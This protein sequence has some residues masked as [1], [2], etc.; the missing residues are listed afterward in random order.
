MDSL[1][2]RNRSRSCF[3]VS[4]IMVF[5]LLLLGTWGRSPALGDGLLSNLK[6]A[7]KDP[8][9]PIFDLEDLSALASE[10]TGQSSLLLNPLPTNAFRENLRRDLQYITTWPANGWS[11]QVIE[12]MNMIYIAQLTHRVPIIPRFRPVHINNENA[13]HL[14]FG[15]VFDVPLLSQTLGMPILEWREVKDAASETLEELG[16]WDIQDKTWERERLYL[17]AP[18]NL[19]LD[20]SYTLAPAWVRSATDGGEDPSTLLWSVAALLS[21]PHWKSLP[22]KPSPVHQAALP[23]DEHLACSNN[24]Y[25]GI[26]NLE[27]E[28][29]HA[30]AWHA[31]GRHIQ[32][33]SE[34]RDVGTRFIRETLGVEDGEVI[35]PYIAI[36]VRRGDFSIW[37]RIRYHKPLSQCFAPLSAY[38]R[39]VEEVKAEIWERRRIRV[40]EV[41]MTSD[42]GNTQWWDEVGKLGW[43]RVDHS[44]TVERFGHWYPIL[45]DAFLQSEA[46]GFVGTATS[47]VSILARRRVE[48][49]G[50]ASSMV[51]WGKEEADDH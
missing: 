45:V 13:S 6:L 40:K 9:P 35:P 7:P 33:R 4:L 38:A 1:L 39:R 32:W 46:V 22:V 17:E 48:S 47:T 18:P 28:E 12:F 42:E 3:L 14:D 31:V 20:L 26:Q 24:L 16:C 37:C 19:K 11:N 49:M 21:F 27:D 50:G 25:W 29:D 44:T 5:S 2:T 41:I 36:H 15:D 23:P 34:V 51:K 43:R 8:G 30:P 10:P